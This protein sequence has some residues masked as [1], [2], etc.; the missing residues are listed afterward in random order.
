MHTHTDTKYHWVKKLVLWYLLNVTVELIM[1][2]INILPV[3]LMH[4][5]VLELFLVYS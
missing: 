3:N 1:I 5:S 2:L 4:I